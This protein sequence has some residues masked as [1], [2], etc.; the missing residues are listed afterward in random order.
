[1]ACSTMT[2]AAPGTCA[3]YA[4][5]SLARAYSSSISSPYSL[6]AMSALAPVISSLK[7]S[8]MG[9]LKL[10]SAPST[11][12]RALFIFSTISARLD[13]EV[14]SLKGFITIST[15]AS[16]T[17]IGSVG[18]S[19]VPILA[20]TCFISGNRSF[21]TFSA[22]SD[23]S[24]LRVSELPAG[25]VICMAK[26]P[27]SNV[28]INSAPSRVKSHRE[29]ASRANATPK[30]DATRFMQVRSPFSY[31]RVSRSKK[32][33]ASEGRVETVRRRKS[34]AIMGT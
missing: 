27:S 21:S 1:M 4:A 19:A 31:R 23:S 15:S 17:D 16:S 10:N 8:W 20:T 28:G 6:M 13:A 25:K 33:S 29:A 32:R 3:T 18:T 9:W 11:S 22:S 34:E 24:M 7:R 2:S 12:S 30:V 5:A 26:S 14:H